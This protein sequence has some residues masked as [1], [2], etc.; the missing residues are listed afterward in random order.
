M[1]TITKCYYL[2][3]NAGTSG[4]T[5]PALSETGTVH[6]WDGHVRNRSAHGRHLT[7]TPLTSRSGPRQAM[8]IFTPL[9][10]PEQAALPNRPGLTKKGHRRDGHMAA[11]S[12]GHMQTSIR[13]GSWLC[14][15]D[16]TAASRH[17][18]GPSR[19]IQPT[20]PHR[21]ISLRLDDR[22]VAGPPRKRMCGNSGL[23][24]KP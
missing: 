19:L 1:D 4:T 2:A 23:T 17:W 20:I 22:V 24:F 14:E 3:S 18:T 7:S 5:Q 13:T 6:R 11:L 21:Q 15:S 8:A 12:S 10:Q 9:E 16:Y